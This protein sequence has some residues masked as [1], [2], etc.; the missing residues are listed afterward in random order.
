MQ[1]VRKP[2]AIVLG[3][4]AL[5]VL[6]HFVFSS[7]YADAVSTDDVWGVLNPLMA[8]SMI[9]TLAVA[10]V[11][12]RAQGGA[13]ADDAT[14]AR[15]CADAAFYASLFLA[16]WFFRNWFDDL[17]AGADGQSANARLIW[18]FIDPLFVILTG[19]AAVRLWVFDPDPN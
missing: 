17:T 18:T 1:A 5:A 3:L 4:I 11:R 6:V 7:F 13:Y 2:L 15:I 14:A 9:V 16:I 12:M 19:H 10:Y 8:F